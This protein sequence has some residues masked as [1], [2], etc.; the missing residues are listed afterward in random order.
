[1]FKNN[2]R[3]ANIKKQFGCWRTGHGGHRPTI[4]CDRVIN[5][6][7]ARPFT[8]L[9]HGEGEAAQAVRGRGFCLGE[10][11]L[12][13]KN[14]FTHKYIKKNFVV[15]IKVANF[16]TWYMPNHPIIRHRARTF[17]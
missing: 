17:I 9:S 16:A 11:L 8:P 1:M 2:A 5:S 6:L 3:S 15:L 4:V 12:F 10:G 7:L 14:R 13:I